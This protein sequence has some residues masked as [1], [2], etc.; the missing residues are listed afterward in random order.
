MKHITFASVL[1]T[2]SFA[3]AQPA[4]Q[5]M[6]GPPPE[7][8]LTGA[9]DPIR[10]PG[11]V[12]LDRG[13]G[14]SRAGG[15]I[16][17]LVLG[18]N[19]DGTALRFDVHGQYVDA[20]SGIGGYAHLPMSFLSGDSDS[21]FELSGAEI[22]GLFAK[23]MSPEMGI[24]VRGGVV[25]PTANEDFDSL[26]QNAITGYARPTDIVNATPNTVVRLG[27]SPV[28][29]SGQLFGRI[30]VGFDI[31]TDS[32]EGGNNTVLRIGPG[33]GFDAGGVA[34]TGELVTMRGFGG[35]NESDFI[36][37]GAIGARMTSGRVAP[38]GAI[39]LP[40]DERVRDFL[41]AAI[42]LGVEAAL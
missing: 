23:R 4:G 27:V 9:P 34:I 7:A 15:E 6:Y 35:D 26:L 24:V 38:Y 29:R 5:P 25:L 20:R 36:S 31:V 21:N 14:T 39:V 12:T 2:S 16:S 41:N 22:G 42:T 8:A 37:F 3:L 30:D 28:F 13:D 10:A 19:A 32:N 40:L 33:I 17:Y 1:L 18:D 11:F